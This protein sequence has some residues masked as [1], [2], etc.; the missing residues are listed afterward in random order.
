MGFTIERPEK[1][2]T[3]ERPK[4]KFTVEPPPKATVG[5]I[6]KQAVIG[7][8]N[9]F[10]L[11]FPLFALEKAKGEEA[12]KKLESNVPVERI[13][14][15]VG[16]TVGIATIFP[17]AVFGAGIKVAR[18]GIK[19]IQATRA[20]RKAR[21][22]L[23][24]IVGAKKATKL[25]K[26]GKAAAE[27]AGA[28]GAFELAH[29]PEETFKEKIITVPT[30]ALF[31]AA[32]FG[33]GDAM[34]PAIKRFLIKKGL[35]RKGYIT[36]NNSGDK[37]VDVLRGQVEEPSG[38]LMKTTRIKNF[39]ET[40]IIDR[41]APIR[42]LQ[43]A[44]EQS[45]S[46]TM[47]F[48]QK[49]FEAARLYSG[50]G[51][52]IVNRLNVLRKILNPQ[53]KFIQPLEQMF[54]AERMLERARRGIKNPRNITEKDA[55]TALGNIRKALGN[56]KFNELRDTT[57]A[58][59]RNV[60]DVMLKDLLD[61]GVVNKRD[62]RNMLR[63]G[64]FYAPFEVLE[65]MESQIGNFASGKNAFTV[66]KTQYLKGVT[67]TLKDINSPLSALMNY[68]QKNT[69]LAERNKVMRK[70][71]NLRSFSN[72]MKKLILPFEGTTLKGFEKV[73]LLKQGVKSEFLVPREVADTIKG[74]NNE[75]I[76]LFTKMA[77]WQTRALRAG[78]TQL[79][80][81]FIVPNMIRDFQTAKLVSKVGFSVGDWVGGMA[82][83]LRRDKSY[84]QFLQSGASFSGFFQRFR[85]TT[86]QTISE[87]VPKI[88]KRVFE[89]TNP[90][91]WV[92]AAAEISENTT[93]LG[94]FKRGLRQGL[95]MPEAAF[96]A[97]NASIDFA[98]SGSVMKIFNMWVPF[99]N[100][101][102]QG[103]VNILKT[104]KNNPGRFAAVGAGLVGLPTTLTFIHNK[105]NFPD[106]WDDIAQ[107]EKDNSFILIYGREKDDRGRWKNIVKIPKG[108][109]G[110][111]LGTPLESFYEYMA[112]EE[113]IEFQKLAL[114]L[115]SNLS[116]IDFES[117]GEFAPNRILS[118]GLPPAVKGLVEG[119]TNK[120]LFTDR[121]IVPRRLE[122]AP[123]REQFDEITSPI[124]ISIGQLI[125]VS[126]LKVENFVGTSFGG[127]GRQALNPLK[128]SEGFLRRFSG[129]FGESEQRRQFDILED[130]TLETNAVKAREYRQV[131]EAL[132]EYKTLPPIPSVRRSF[133]LTN[134]GDNTKLQL[135]FIE[136][137]KTEQSG[138]MPIHRALKTATIE[139]R[140]KFISAYSNTL[141]TDEQRLQFIIEIVQQKIITAD[142]LKRIGK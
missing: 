11:G 113:P 136:F 66:A 125:N 42:W 1:K 7:F 82:S 12:R 141:D 135:R 112:S 46:K 3:I 121:E 10:A 43:E 19:T 73:S 129:A 79:N 123:P 15:G 49:P 18:A 96:N 98:K 68:I 48:S 14:R 93:R 71:T 69:N 58:I 109:L 119:V 8:G 102:T 128:A 88:S 29:A 81:A 85:R 78:A 83:A 139:E 130:V 25:V 56:Q 38:V 106:I 13:A 108:D 64:E 75:T 74:L 90:F 111:I 53:R 70:I 52:K 50:V 37:V 59:R 117:E 22:G 122:K 16:T 57:R 91:K 137:L 45:T 92:S 95:K 47:R 54:T 34:A 41:M 4:P 118:S 24:S 17:K 131:R 103:A 99:L 21:V 116:P 30:A 60:T 132:I 5:G 101:R 63:S 40:K 100:A 20:A 138:E 120:N 28:I 26:F 97:R 31:G 134:F 114:Q 55:V 65:H 76:D 104:V 133:I 62:Y 9:E 77:S 32:T 107:F 115:A 39:I 35:L 44:A 89:V 110:K 126:P 33:I 105:L 124:A 2:F 140:L 72:D 23:R 61:A 51:G 94:V 27:G 84:K 80:L 36:A 86:P 142:S 6:A 127:V 87:L 67:G